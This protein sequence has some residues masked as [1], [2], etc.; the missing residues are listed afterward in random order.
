MS[1]LNNSSQEPDQNA[2]N[3]AALLIIDDKGTSFSN[4]NN[5]AIAYPDFLQAVR[6]RIDDLAQTMSSSV[7][8]NIIRSFIPD[9]PERWQGEHP[10]IGSPSP[11]YGFAAL[12]IDQEKLEE[13]MDRIILEIYKCCCHLGNDRSP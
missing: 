12:G 7:Y 1:S 9:N 3:L 10:P 6:Q 4:R 2:F 8:N 11:D 5:L 13:T